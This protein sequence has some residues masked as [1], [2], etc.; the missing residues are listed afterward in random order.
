M[1]QDD[2]VAYTGQQIAGAMG[3]L[4]AR[5]ELSEQASSQAV[6]LVAKESEKFAQ[7]MST[8][9]QQYDWHVVEKIKTMGETA[10]KHRQ[11]GSKLVRLLAQGLLKLKLK[12]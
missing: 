2:F 6:Q 1:T 3:P 9:M 12:K 4:N 7:K 11:A 5:I 10:E 8:D